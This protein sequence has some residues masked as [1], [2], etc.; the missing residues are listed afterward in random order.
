MDIKVS[1]DKLIGRWGDQENLIYVTW[2][3]LKTVHKDEEGD[4][5]RKKSKTMSGVKPV[6]NVGKNPQSFLE[7][8]PLQK[9]VL[10]SYKL[11]GHAYE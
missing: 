7:I 9:E 1:K 8:S 5:L 4:W 11:Q 3:E 2:N 6:E 10:L